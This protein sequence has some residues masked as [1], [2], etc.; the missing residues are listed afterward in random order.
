MLFRSTALAAIHLEEDQVEAAQCAY[1]HALEY[2]AC[3]SEAHQL[4]AW[5]FV[6]GKIAEVVAGQ[7]TGESAGILVAEAIA[8]YQQASTAFASLPSRA[9][10]AE[11][12]GRLAR[13]LETSGRQSEAI[14]CWKSAY[15]IY[16][17]Q[18]EPSVSS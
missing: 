15:A 4:G 3:I 8:C 10:L 1:K 16:D 17:H 7:A 13:I 5:H 6:G 9:D 12:Y 2:Q 18:E 11:V 14:A